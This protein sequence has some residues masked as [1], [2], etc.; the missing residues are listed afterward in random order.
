MSGTAMATMTASRH[1]RLN[2]MRADT[3]TIATQSA[4]T[5]SFTFPSAVT[6]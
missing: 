3:M 4:R 2:M 6:P 5:S 1:P